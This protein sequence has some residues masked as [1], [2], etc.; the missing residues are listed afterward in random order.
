[1]I[2]KRGAKGEDNVTGISNLIP[3]AADVDPDTIGGLETG[4]D[5]GATDVADTGATVGLVPTEIVY[6]ILFLFIAD[7]TGYKTTFDH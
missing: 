7:F 6:F 3:C 2:R 5:T 4:L 1:M